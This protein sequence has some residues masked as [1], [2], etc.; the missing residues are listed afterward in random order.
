[1]PPPFRLGDGERSFKAHM[2]TNVAAQVLRKDEICYSTLQFRSLAHDTTCA[3]KWKIFNGKHPH[4][5]TCTL[6]DSIFIL[7][8]PQLYW[9]YFIKDHGSCLTEFTKGT[10][11][12]AISAKDG[13]LLHL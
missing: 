12:Q 1:M 6:L 3:T 8:V 5:Y 11:W 9:L 13:F 7:F 4:S 2:E 10:V